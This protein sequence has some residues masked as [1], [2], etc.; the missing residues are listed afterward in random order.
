LVDETLGDTRPL[1][2]RGRSLAGDILPLS[3]F[4]GEVLPLSPLVGDVLPL[5]GD[6]LPLISALLG[7]ALPLS[8][9]EV[10]LVGFLTC[11]TKYTRQ[12]FT[13]YPERWLKLW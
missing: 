13:C 2:D 10:L 12:Y 11:E 8:A 3:P 6:F 9:F 7:V 5:V 4:V 1:E